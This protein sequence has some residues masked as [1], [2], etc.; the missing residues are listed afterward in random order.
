MG[1]IIHMLLQTI[2]VQEIKKFKR[3]IKKGGDYLARFAPD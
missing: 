3:K 2:K 1:R